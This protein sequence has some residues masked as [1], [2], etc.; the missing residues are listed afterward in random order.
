MHI[1]DS[2]RN[3]QHFETTHADAVGMCKLY[4]KKFPGSGI[5]P[6]TLWLQGDGANHHDAGGTVNFLLEYQTI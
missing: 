1:F 6:A 5:K 2:G 4:S 3:P